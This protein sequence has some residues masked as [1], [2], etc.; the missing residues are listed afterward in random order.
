MRLI[1]IFFAITLTSSVFAKE[2]KSYKQF[3][4]ETKKEKLSS[5]D[6]LKRDRLSNTITWQNAN[7]FNLINKFSSEY[8]NIVQRRDFYSWLN[9]E[10]TKK[11]HEI[12]WVKMAHFISKKNTLN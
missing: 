10:L 4:K 12:V 1:I 2:Y 5:S 7:H 11:G 8:I 9:I 6:W 3:Q